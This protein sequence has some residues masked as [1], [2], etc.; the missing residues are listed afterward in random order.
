MREL[1][2]GY[3][4]NIALR[5]RPGTV[6][7]Y[8]IYLDTHI[9]PFFHPSTYADTITPPQIDE[10][11]DHRLSQGVMATTVNKELSCVRR[12]FAY[13]RKFHGLRTNPA[14]IVESLDSDSIPRKRALTP[15]EV[16]KLYAH[17]GPHLRPWIVTDYL[18]GA[19]AAECSH[20]R[21][22]DLDFGRRTVRLIGDPQTGHNP[23]TAR[24]GTQ[25]PH[26]ASAGGLPTRAPSTPRHSLHLHWY[27]RRTLAKC[28]HSIR[29]HC[30][31][32]SAESGTRSRRGRGRIPGS[33]PTGPGNAPYVAAFVGD[34]AGRARSRPA[35]PQEVGWL[36]ARHNCE[37]LRRRGSN[38]EAAGQ[39]GADRR[40]S[41]L[42]A[43]T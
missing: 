16:F 32:C 2:D 9:V 36:D 30:R 5:R 29:Q 28:P 27:G 13:A 39:A 3:L 37:S 25:P 14:R 20:L 10:Y 6:E 4:D 31:A 7:L 12:L 18:L 40:D 8:R 42:R 15:A 26:G 11:L 34:H 41:I 35:R 21:R 38:N 1:R 43:D 22:A 24:F 33:I 23:K 19:R 17:A